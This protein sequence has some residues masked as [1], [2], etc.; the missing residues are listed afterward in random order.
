M[1]KSIVWRLFPKWNYSRREKK[2]KPKLKLNRT[3]RKPRNEV[4][5]LCFCSGEN[6]TKMVKS[7]VNF[8][9][10]ITFIW[11]LRFAMLW[12]K[13]FL[14]YFNIRESSSQYLVW[15]LLWLLFS[16]HKEKNWAQYFSSSALFGNSAYDW[17]FFFP[18]VNLFFVYL[19]I[20]LINVLCVC[21]CGI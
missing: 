13:R 17:D 15:L 8:N 18:P 6:W 4:N 12:N 7:S 14:K 2:K 20:Y 21:V 11:D 10:I 16:I 3:E 9:I 5:H 19:F 1:E